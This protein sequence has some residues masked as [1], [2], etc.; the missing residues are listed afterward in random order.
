MFIP[1]ES[2]TGSIRTQKENRSPLRQ[3]APGRLS[4]KRRH[5]IDTPSAT[6][7]KT[8]REDANVSDSEVHAEMVG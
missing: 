6:G 5:R 2:W 7:L 4:S 3:Q 8:V 1:S